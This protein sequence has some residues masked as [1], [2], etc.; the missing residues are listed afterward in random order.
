MPATKTTTGKKTPARPADPDRP[1]RVRNAECPRCG[2]P[3]YFSRKAWLTCRGTCPARYA[4]NP[5]E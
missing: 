1:V 4:V 3:I 5:A 2:G